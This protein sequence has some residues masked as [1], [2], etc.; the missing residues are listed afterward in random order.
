MSSVMLPASPDVFAPDGSEV[1]LLAAAPAGSMAEFRL[2]PDAIA[3][4]ILHRSVTELWFVVAG[5]GRLWRKH[6]DDESELMLEPGLSLTI[7][8]GCH[9]QFRC[10]GDAALRVIGVTIPP[11][12]GE[13]EAV[14]ITGKW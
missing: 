2:P 8:P 11:W 12:P 6:G 1:R 10:D 13:D 14:F 7:L 5:Y 9:F 3:K 4:A